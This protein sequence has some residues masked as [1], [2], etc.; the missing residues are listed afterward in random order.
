MSKLRLE[1]DSLTIH[2]PK[3]RWNLYFILETEDPTTPG[4]ML[5][6]VIPGDSTI[7]VRG[8]AD[9]KVSFGHSGLFVLE[10]DIDTST[11]PAVKARVWLIH[12]R[13]SAR[14][15]SELIS[16]I[17]GA[18]KDL[19]GQLETV[20]SALNTALPWFHVVSSAAVPV[21]SIVAKITGLVK[22]R[23]MGFLSMDEAFS[24]DEINAGEVS[25]EYQ[26]SSGYFSLR[27]TWVI[28]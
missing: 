4:K 26:S 12:D 6:T 20:N 22:D 9:N 15:T 5:A 10:R 25:G 21:S 23:N 24:H 18:V 14:R 17:S 16:E 7:P 19:G 28:Y 11:T 27:Y 13:A 2:R 8:P 3:E 1:L